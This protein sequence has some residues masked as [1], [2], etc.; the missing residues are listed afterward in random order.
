M[1]AVEPLSIEAL[2]RID[3]RC[4]RF[5]REL[6]SNDPHQRDLADYLTDTSGL[7]RSTLLVELLSLDL[8][9]RRRRG[10]SVSPEDYAGLPEEDR[11][12]VANVLAKFSQRHAGEVEPANHSTQVRIHTAPA[13]D[14]GAAAD[15]ELPKQFGRYRVLNRIAVGG[16][17]IV[18]RG[19]DDELQ[20]D[21][22]IKMPHRDVV[23]SG[24]AAARFLT[25]ARLVASLHHPAIVPVYDVGR[26]DA[27]NCYVVSK[28]MEGGD[29][30]GRARRATVTPREA[31]AIVQRV[32]DAAHYAHSRGLI[33]RDIKPSNLLADA[34]GQVF[35]G[36]F[37]AAAQRSTQPAFGFVGTPAYMSPEQARG[38]NHLVD[39]R[40]DVFS[41]GVVLYE[42]TTGQRPFRNA[43]ISQLLSEVIAAS[44]VPPRQL[45]SSIAPEL[46]RITLRAMAKRASDRYQSARELARELRDW[47]TGDE[48]DGSSE[49]PSQ[50]EIVPK[51][52]RSFEA[53]D[54]EY[55]LRLLPGPRDR[56]GVPESIRF[57][58]ARIEE[59]LPSRTFRVG[60]VYGPSGCGKSSLV[61]AGLLP[62]LGAR[63]QPIYLEARR[64]STESELLEGLK[65]QLPIPHDG[66]L[67]EV[68]RSLRNEPQF[69]QPKILIVID[70]FEQ[71]L[72]T[73]H[74]VAHA[75]LTRALRQCD[76]MRL[77][78]L[79]LVRDD[80]WMP[81]VRF[82]SELEVT[83]VEHT[84]AMAVDL[85]DLAHA[86]KIL[87]RFG[88]AYERLPMNLSLL[89]RDHV[90]FL[91]EALRSLEQ[92]GTVNPICLSLFVEMTKTDPWEPATLRRVGGTDGLGLRYLQRCFSPSHPT[93]R[94]RSHEV[95][96]RNVLG[97]L[98]PDAGTDIRVHLRSSA[99]LM[100]ASGY[101]DHQDRF[102]EL[103][104]LL[105]QEL[106]LITPTHPESDA[107]VRTGAPG[108]GES[109][110]NNERAAKQEHFYQLSHDFMV[111]PIRD[112]VTRARQQTIRGRA[113][114]C[115]DE[116][117]ALWAR[118]QESRQ[119]PGL[120]EW[121]QIRLFTNRS[122]WNTTQQ[123]ML[124]LAARRCMLQFVVLLG[125]VLLLTGAGWHVTGQIRAKSALT[126]VRRADT[127]DLLAVIQDVQPLSRW[128]TPMLARE[129]TDPSL[130][131]RAQRN[132]RLALLV[133]DPSQS[134]SLHRDL[135]EVHPT[136]MSVIRRALQDYA[137]QASRDEIIGSLWNVLRDD[138]HDDER[139]LRAACALAGLDP[140]SSHWNEH[141]EEITTW[142]VTMRIDQIV[143]WLDL[144]RP[145]SQ[146][147]ISSL[148]Q[149]FLS[150]DAY[151]G[152]LIA[153]FALAN[154]LDD[155]D[156]AERIVELI[157]RAQPAQISAL[158]TTIRDRSES[159]RKL[160]RREAQVTFSAQDTALPPA[161]YKTPSEAVVQMIA[162]AH[163]M[164]GPRF[165]FCQMLPLNQLRDLAESMR[166]FSYRPI[167]V[168]P[169]QHDSRLFVAVIWTRDA[170]DWQIQYPLSQSDVETQFSKGRQQQQYFGDVAAYYD[171]DQW[172]FLV[173]SS[174][175]P[176]L[177]ANERLT[178]AISAE[179]SQAT[180]DANIAEQ[181]VPQTLQLATDPN[182]DVR[183]TQIWYR[184]ASRII[185]E[186][187]S[188]TTVERLQYGGRNYVIVDSSIH[189]LP[190]ERPYGV[191][192]RM[193]P[194][195]DNQTVLSDSPAEL[196]DHANRLYNQGYRPVA[197]SLKSTAERAEPFVL[198]VWQRPVPT[199]EAKQ[200][201]ADIRSNLLVAL[202]SL[203]EIDAALPSLRSSSSATL[204]NYVTQKIPQA[205]VPVDT[206][207]ACLQ[208]QDLSHDGRQAIILAI[209]SCTKLSVPVK[210]RTQVVK[211][212]K[213]QAVWDDDPGIHAAATLALQ[214]WQEAVPELEPTAAGHVS[215]R[216]W[217]TNQHQQKFAVL[218]IPFSFR[219]ADAIKPRSG[220]RFAIG[221][222]EVTQRQFAKFRPQHRFRSNRVVDDNCPAD[223]MS[224]YTA[225]EYCNWLSAQE[226]LPEWEWC[227]EPNEAGDYASGMK[228]T[229]DYLQRRGYRLP[230][231]AEWLYAATDGKRTP[232]F[233][234][235]DASLL[236]EYGWLAENAKHSLHPVGQLLPNRFGLFDVYG[237]VKE[238]S[239][240]GD[241]P[242]RDDY[243]V[244]DEILRSVLGTA[245]VHFDHHVKA[246]SGKHGN[247][248]ALREDRNGFR[249]AK[250]IFEE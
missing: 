246:N 19:F 178:L 70:Q 66:D 24:Q 218:Q 23:S 145:V 99:E 61:K 39:A 60:V 228:I 133:E 115:L 150:T 83:P 237:N 223:G 49:P 193:D 1:Q 157:K 110:A 189:S 91:D 52:L 207:F 127:N 182:G 168:R 153:S 86:K 97:A 111:A 212:L 188:N 196:R 30:S 2:E 185:F 81:L 219:P 161:Q 9:Y 152:S 18:L 84:N 245:F 232:Y 217:F 34:D 8:E 170:F 105:D 90:R 131:A 208:R 114:L 171:Q 72:H 155:R 138:S 167:R 197:I 25:E 143:D 160:L 89:T 128:L 4:C 226:G 63:V 11:A 151:G 33:H 136:E 29:L 173:V 67:T 195:L 106:R 93:S 113:E 202:L 198:S 96:V 7:E 118:K 42:L 200:R 204:L 85:F 174:N 101:Q 38:E 140:Q 243:L 69:P 211:W 192:W 107:D 222:T 121:I 80:F 68:L 56:H 125:C 16:S 64:D 187:R 5:E 109:Q 247:P 92:E 132:M 130:S 123:R 146:Y 53:T 250:T 231:A 31:A 184:A 41:L 117:T 14:S 225:A 244:T 183:K 51:G 45:N 73:H 32:A 209:G 126:T 175:D 98:L 176:S 71:W 229:R 21:V 235:T 177:A 215:E 100:V 103:M 27:G 116:R 62:R 190:N 3:E 124:T 240:S 37:G 248:P 154:F 169:F 43:N 47:L 203:G 172:Q 46:E 137:D 163:G 141:A 13:T 28:F 242:T 158:V 10:E 129:I 94:Y 221:M 241:R 233:F 6:K 236:V 191:I 12:T 112:W 230:L 76:G 206:L 17:G 194:Y 213:E 44:P 216:R 74:D 166:E 135:M 108:G 77:Q 65:K 224:W 54:A 159:A 59:T 180:F 82:M 15:Q 88:Q 147:L 227:Y 20:R 149:S 199:E 48:R 134:T 40:T 144:L 36:D 148:E 79:L 214:R 165:A 238:W 104:N 156:E 239:Q 122:T 26:T 119:L 55:F 22:A 249:L 50:P 181:F 87:I 210:V 205:R 58:Q 75:E 201:F 164:I 220:H 95:A 186:Q 78:C 139:R 162:D 35:L 234:G 179:N 142:L 57:W 102:D 120:F